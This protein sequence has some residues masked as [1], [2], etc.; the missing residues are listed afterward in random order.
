MQLAQKLLKEDLR[1]IEIC[2]REYLTSDVP[3][4]RQMSDYI[5][6]S[7]GKRIRPVLLLLCAHL[8]GYEGE[9]RYPLAC[10][11]EYLHTATL[12][13]DDVV[14]GATLRRGQVAANVAWGNDVAV[15][16]G[17]YLFA[18]CFEI[19]VDFCDRRIMQ[20]LAGTTSLMAQGEVVQLT[21]SGDISL[22]EE[23]YLA[24]VRRKTAALFAATC[25]CGAIL[26]RLSPEK[27]EALA[28]FGMDLGVAFQ[29]VDDVLDYVADQ[30]ESGKVLGRDLDEGKM[31]LP[32]IHALR[33]CRDSEKELVREIFSKDVLGDEDLAF[34]QQL[35][36]RY[37][38][39]GYA[40]QQAD[41]YAAKACSRL[42]D[43]AD[44]PWRRALV[45]LAETAARRRC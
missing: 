31:T 45:D 41:Y 37:D 40:R 18:R 17:D 30:K 38:G 19:M 42:Q 29:L 2:F 10:V 27:E 34:V 11:I 32:L 21:N 6:V 1:H 33:R 7:G 28:A 8:S 25:R 5:L 15:L 9:E 35:I 3:L 36:G 16:V 13:H 20:V 22:N 44:S 23:R 14:D 4:I 43:F 24:V 26:G 12:L 39:V